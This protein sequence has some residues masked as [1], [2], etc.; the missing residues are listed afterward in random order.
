MRAGRA[1]R[2]ED[3]PILVTGEIVHHDVITRVQRRNQLPSH[4]G[5]E[6]LPV[7]WRD[8]LDGRSYCLIQECSRALRSLTHVNVPRS[9]GFLQSEAR[10][11]FGG[12]GSCGRPA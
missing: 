5:Q 7:V 2:P 4:P 1:D 10:L 6:D 12:H 8:N 11:G 3:V 9:C